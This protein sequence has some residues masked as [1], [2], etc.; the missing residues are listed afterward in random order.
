MGKLPQ[1]IIM[2]SSFEHIWS[3]VNGALYWHV[4]YDDNNDNDRLHTILC[5][6]L[7]DRKFS[8]IVLPDDDD[9]KP[10]FDL[11]VLGGQLCMIN[12]DH[13]CHSDIWAWEG[14]NYNK[15]GSNWIKL[16]HI[17][18]NHNKYFAPVFLMKNGEV[19][20][21]IIQEYIRGMSYGRRRRW[22]C[23]MDFQ[24]GDKNLFIYNQKN[25]TVR[26]LTI[27]YKRPYYH[28]EITCTRS[29]VSPASDAG[30]DHESPFCNETEITLLCRD[31]SDVFIAVQ[32]RND[33]L[34]QH[35]T[36]TTREYEQEVKPI[37]EHLLSEFGP[38]CKSSTSWVS[39]QWTIELDPM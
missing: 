28:K 27:P 6:D 3:F 38:H 5:F 21:R 36:T 31:L 34:Q 23:E 33:E 4:E 12:Y 11:G 14:N 17:P 16:M 22:R 19:V 25:K 32:E 8:M 35:S 37:C 2:S 7:V 9:K 20:L 15:K 26:E 30:D 39:L 29:L 13:D 24:K 1:Q 18:S 10:D